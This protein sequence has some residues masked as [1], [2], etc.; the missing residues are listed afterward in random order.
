[1]VQTLTLQFNLNTVGPLQRIEYLIECLDA[2]M[3]ATGAV[4]GAKT[5]LR[6]PYKLCDGPW[7]TA[8]TL[9]CCCHRRD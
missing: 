9:S 3:F 1:M 6:P 2:Q 7:S 8:P 5:V 4:T